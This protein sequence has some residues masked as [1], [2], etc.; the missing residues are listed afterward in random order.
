VYKGKLVDTGALVAVKMI[1]PEK[2]QHGGEKEF[3]SEV[4]IISRVHHRNLVKL[5]GCCYDRSN[6]LLVYDYM[7]NGSLDKLLVRKKP[8][9]IISTEE[10]SISNDSSAI[11]SKKDHLTWDVRFKIVNAI[12]GALS[13]LHEE[14]GQC[15]LHRDVKP[16]NVLLDS[17]FNA[18]LADFGLA[19]LFDHDKMAPTMTCGGTPGYIAPEIFQSGRFT[20]K[21][22]VYSFGILALE[23]ACGR[24]PIEPE[25][26]ASEVIL[27]DWVWAAHESDDL[28]R[29]VDPCLGFEYDESEM[30]RLL[31]VGLLCCIVDPEGRV[32]MMAARNMLVGTKP[33]T[34][35]PETKPEV[36][37]RTRRKG[38][39]KPFNIQ[40]IPSSTGSSSSGTSNSIYSLSQ[41][42]GITERLKPR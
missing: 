34:E 13:Y 37:Y 16:S 15:I 8:S 12:A 2:F 24:R 31:Q 3:L 29:V 18:Y 33:I 42:D 6:M 23:V 32:S 5:Q 4:S 40:G 14:C 39:P 35:L 19:R 7:E 9:I 25:L 22:D 28:L 30:K 11:I 21:S 36:H 27:L 41:S 38:D 1:S 17:E 10:L 20:T 26:S